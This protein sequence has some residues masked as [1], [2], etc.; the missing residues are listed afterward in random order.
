MFMLMEKSKAKQNKTSKGCRIPTER[1]RQEGSQQLPGV[2]GLR[3]G[4]PRGAP[5]GADLS[6]FVVTRGGSI[7]PV[8]ITPPWLLPC[9][10]QTFHPSFSSQ[11][12]RSQVHGRRSS[13][14]KCF[15]RLRTNTARE[16]RAQ[17]S[18]APG[19]VSSGKELMGLE[20]SI[21]TALGDLD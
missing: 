21:G 7:A 14:W 9:S 19:A 13:R 4:V 3:E 18:R 17:F 1:P 15:E 8:F 5:T 16:S 12:R 11:A 20:P 2:M 10:A 6:P